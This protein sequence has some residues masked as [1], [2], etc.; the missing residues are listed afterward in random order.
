M[1]GGRVVFSSRQMAELDE[2]KLIT[3]MVGEWVPPVSVARH[4]EE[5]AA[6]LLEVVDLEIHDDRER[7]ILSHINFTLSPREILG[8]AGISGNGQRELAEALLGLRPIHHGEIRVEGQMVNHLSPITMLD[9][10]VVGIP[11]N[12]VEEAIV[13]GLTVLEHMVLGG[14]EAKRRGLGIDWPAVAKEFQA[15]PEATT[16]RVA[17]AERRADGLSGGN[18]QRMIL[19]RALARKPRIL[20]AS[21]PSRGLDIATTRAVHQI[22]LSH[23]DQGTAI[24]LF[25]EDLNELY[26]LSDRLLVVSHERVSAPIDPRATDIYQVAAQMVTRSH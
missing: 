18:V 2:P 16:L 4:Q 14:L 11:E 12:P 17:A 3:Q 5:L 23:R 7:P 19:G 25:S 22:L 6:P 20:I 15:L 21:Y 24:L 26:A 1:R 13:P 9:A 8:V 10:G